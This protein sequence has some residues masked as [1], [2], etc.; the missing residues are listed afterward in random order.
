MGL[1]GRLK[2]KRGKEGLVNL[3]IG[4]FLIAV[5]LY[6]TVGFYEI[7]RPFTLA[8]AFVLLVAIFYFSWKGMKSLWFNKRSRRT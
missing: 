3:L 6:V 1:V 4:Q 5:L 2:E 7:S 8:A